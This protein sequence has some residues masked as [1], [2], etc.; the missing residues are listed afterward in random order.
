MSFA[1]T[2][3]VVTQRRWLLEIF[4]A[5]GCD[6]KQHVLYGNE[7][8][9]RNEAKSRLRR[10]GESVRLSELVSP[11]SYRLAVEETP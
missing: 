7:E 5:T 3:D 2:G 10:I 4:D 1:N 11:T 9:V 8:A 6:P